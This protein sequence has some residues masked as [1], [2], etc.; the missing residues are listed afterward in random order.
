VTGVQTCALP[1]YIVINILPIKIMT[2][3]NESDSNIILHA[4]YLYTEVAL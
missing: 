4:V 2:V 1:I 3:Q